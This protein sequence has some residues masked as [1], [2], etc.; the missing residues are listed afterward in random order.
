MQSA[1]RG[2][3][4]RS[5]LAAIGI[6]TMISVLPARASTKLNLTFSHGNAWA[7]NQ[8]VTLYFS[9]SVVSG[10]T[11]DKGTVSFNIESGNGF[12]IVVN[13][14]RLSKF[15][16]IGSVPVLIDIDKVGVIHW[17]GGSSQ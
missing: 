8:P 2:T 4:Y 9:Q 16:Q 10:K 11:N 14:Q 15:Y 7:V 13:G 3:G 1:K 17:R 12:W 6:L 5:L